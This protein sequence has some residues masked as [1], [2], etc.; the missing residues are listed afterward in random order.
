MNS[1]AIKRQLLAAIAMV[2]VA[3][4]ALGS[5]TYAWFVS[6]STVTAK[7]MNVQAMAESGLAISHD[8]QKWGSVSATSLTPKTLAP[9]S[10]KDLTNWYHA[11]A[12]DPSNYAAAT[13]ATGA[14]EN[15]TAQVLPNGNYDDNNSYVFRDKF[16]IR[17]TA[18]GENQSKGLYVSSITVTTSSAA[19]AET[20]STALRVGVAYTDKTSNNTV[21]KIFAPVSV[22]NGTSNNPTKT[23]TV[24]DENGAA[25]GDSF[26]VNEYGATSANLISADTAISSTNSI[27]VYIY[28]WFEG[29]DRN[30]YSDNFY[31]EDLF[32]SVEFSSIDSTT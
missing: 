16:E 24:Y 6:S 21:T 12:L 2:L 28:I 1:K 29:E 22:G 17:S 27:S 31:A 13:G 3:A 14:R 19:A 11:T 4:V 10:T 18:T 5:S 26:T 20:M 30:L 7:G 32:V 15:V 23:Y 8:G 9:T 25:I